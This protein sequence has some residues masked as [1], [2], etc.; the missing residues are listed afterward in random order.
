MKKLFWTKT[1]KTSIET[2]PLTI[3]QVRSQYSDMILIY[4]GGSR[5]VIAKWSKLLEGMKYV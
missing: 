3:V 2:I 4:E 1:I 5:A